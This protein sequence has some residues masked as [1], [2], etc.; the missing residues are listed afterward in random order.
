MPAHLDDLK[1]LRNEL[2][3]EA[4]WRAQ[5]LNL[6]ASEN[7]TSPIVNQILANDF[8]YR[9]GDYKGLNL[10]DRKYQGNRYITSIEEKA[11]D[12]GKKLLDA[13]F[14]D[15]RPLSGHVAGIAVL[16]AL[17]EPGDTVM[18]LD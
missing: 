11:H 12:L 1:F 6:I 15:L 9:Y 13:H 2:Q 16:M 5:C 17:T 7:T 4:K 8:S 3:A 10:R 14:I 18:E